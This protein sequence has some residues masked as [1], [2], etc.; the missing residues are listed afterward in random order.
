M[1]QRGIPIEPVPDTFQVES[2][3][4]FILSGSRSQVCH[5]RSPTITNALIW[6][7]QEEGVHF[8]CIISI[9]HCRERGKKV[10]FRQ[11]KVMPARKSEVSDVNCLCHTSGLKILQRWAVQRDV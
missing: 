9:T 3:V 10:L 5:K 2:H 1:F 4:R 11:S 8:K 7:K 6:T